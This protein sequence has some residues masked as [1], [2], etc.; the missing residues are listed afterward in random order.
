[1]PGPRRGGAKYTSF[2]GMVCHYFD[3]KDSYLERTSLLNLLV[4]GEPIA[5]RSHGIPYHQ[6]GGGKACG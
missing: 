1:M 6:S 5:R 4:K 3:L 2:A